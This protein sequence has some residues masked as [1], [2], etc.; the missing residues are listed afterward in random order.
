MKFG[1][2]IGLFFRKINRPV[3]LFSG[4]MRTSGRKE[5]K[6][7]ARPPVGTGRENERDLYIPVITELTD[8]LFSCPSFSVMAEMVSLLPS[9]AR[10]MMDTPLSR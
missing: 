5:A 7:E 8:T 10:E 9:T 4:R 3:M 6:K 1:M 2:T